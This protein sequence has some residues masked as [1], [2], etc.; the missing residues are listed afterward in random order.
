MARVSMRRLT[1][2]LGLSAAWLLVLCAPLLAHA[3]LVEMFPREGAT[4][5]QS[6]EQ[7]RLRFSEPIEAE[8]DPLKVYDSKGNRVDRDDA[9]VDPDDARVLV[10]DLEADLPEGLYKVEWRITSVDGHVVGDTYRF[11]VSASASKPEDAARAG[12]EGAEGPEARPGAQKDS[13]GGGF[14][15]VATYSALSLGILGLAALVLLGATW[16][17][18]RRS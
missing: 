11:A 6:P 16:L 7:V 1:V 2:L 3:R 10:A 15:Q 17:R 18:R 8:F 12:A 14:G 4:L 9:R 13:D 5:S